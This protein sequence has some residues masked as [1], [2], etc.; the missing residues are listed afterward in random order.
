MRT[1]EYVFSGTR[2]DLELDLRPGDG[3]YENDGPT[4]FLLDVCLGRAAVDRAPAL[5]G[6]RSVAI[7]EA[8]WRSSR[9]GRPVDVA[10]T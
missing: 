6:V 10:P 5:V 2:A 3:I 8:A 7:I 9:E 1:D 4:Q